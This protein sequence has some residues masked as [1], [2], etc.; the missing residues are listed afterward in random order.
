LLLISGYTS[1]T[2]IW[3]RGLVLLMLLLGGNSLFG[4]LILA[5]KI[6][7]LRW[8][9][10][11]ERTIFWFILEKVLLNFWLGIFAWLIYR[12]LRKLARRRYS[13]RS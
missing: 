9:L 8:E 13:F 6:S 7:P 3:Q 1:L 11:F 10:L 2:R 4:L 12:Y 5:R